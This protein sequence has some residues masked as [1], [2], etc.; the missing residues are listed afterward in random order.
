MSAPDPQSA[1]VSNAPASASRASA[2]SAP[3]LHAELASSWER[4][5]EAW[6]TAVRSGAIPSRRAGTDAAILDAVRRAGP[7]HILDVGCGEGWLVRAL[8]ADGHEVTGVDA[9]APLIA[10]AE[11]AP[12]PAGT[13]RIRYA[14][15]DYAALPALAERLGAPFDIAVCNFALLGDDL[16][17]TLL[18]I[19]ALLADHGTL[20]IQTM[21]PWSACGDAPYADGWRTET[22]DAFGGQFPTPMPWFFRT[23]SSWCRTISDAGF[24]LSA[25]N[26]PVAPGASLPLSLVLTAR[27]LH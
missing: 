26:E 21:H 19:R 22:F 3:D 6:T 10:A 15:A 24:Q 17:D 4:N 12:A 8:A 11:A 20:V 1:R 7:G 5:A 14:V 16:H 23:L 2:A 13:G 25:V 18:A 27:A 9:S